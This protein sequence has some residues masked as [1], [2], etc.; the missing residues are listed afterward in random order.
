MGNHTSTFTSDDHA[1]QKKKAERKA[2]KLFKQELS[3]D[4]SY[5]KLVECRT[6]DWQHTSFMHNYLVL[7]ADR[8]AMTTKAKPSV[9]LTLAKSDLFRDKTCAYF[10]FEL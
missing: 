5:E 9:V 7:T 3:I 4:L 1:V 6:E 8:K 2:C 10:I